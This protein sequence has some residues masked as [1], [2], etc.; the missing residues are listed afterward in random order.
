MIK[1]EERRY[2]VGEAQ[3]LAAWGARH[4]S[5]SGEIVGLGSVYYREGDPS[6]E[7]R[8]Q[9]S[10]GEPI[11]ERVVPGAFSDI[12]ADEGRDV[13]AL[14]NHDL[15]Q[16][17][18]RRSAGTLKLFDT[19]EGLGYRITPADTTLANDLRANLQ[20]RNIT[21]SSIGF[22][23][24]PGGTV[25]TDEGSVRVSTITKVGHL[26]DVGPVTTPAFEGTE[27]MLR[28]IGGRVAD[29]IEA[30][31]RAEKRLLAISMGSAILDR[32]S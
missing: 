32:Y 5:D 26:R 21:G 17:L 14:F 29:Q 20:A 22:Y 24:A 18:G 31:R 7:Y 13:I 4:R 8:T 11:T 16:V 10:L 27:A 23:A 30:R 15:N 3:R 28:S 25:I 1:N 2:F 6:T 19:D 12:L 9:S